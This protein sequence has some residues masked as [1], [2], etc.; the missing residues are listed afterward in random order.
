MMIMRR[1]INEG[2]DPVNEDGVTGRQSSHFALRYC[3]VLSLVSVL[4]NS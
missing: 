2:V 3:G 1:R 4:V